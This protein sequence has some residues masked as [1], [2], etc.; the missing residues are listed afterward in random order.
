MNS[1]TVESCGKINIFLHILG[2]R[3]DGFHE[4]HTLFA[5]IGIFDTI[6]V[7][8]A[9]KFSITCDNPDIPTDERNIISKVKNILT[10][11][12]QIDCCHRVD[13]I[14]RIPD[15]GGLGGGSSNAAAYLKAVLQLTGTDMPM[16]VKTDVMARV[17]SD[18]AF[19]LHG[20]PMVGTGRGE[21]LTPWGIL[22]PA[23][24]LLVN[25][26]VHVSTA[27][28]FSSGNLQLT[29][30]AELNK[31]P[32]IVNFEQYGDILFNGLEPAVL[33]FYPAVSQAKAALE[34]AGADFALMS[35]SGATVFGLFRDFDCALRAEKRIAGQNPDWKCFLTKLT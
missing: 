27:Q 23:F 12:C 6:T 24:V 28:V 32:H 30:R 19:F 22:P 26:S 17:G 33:P 3:P 15:G 10:N 31:I 11:D 4:L 34:E 7:T 14:K 25:P 1:V 29:D 16:S 9:D 18:T 20:T 35:G 5:P 13:I 2:K 21:I 8:E